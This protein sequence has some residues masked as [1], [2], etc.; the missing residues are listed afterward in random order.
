MLLA[1][2]PDSALAK[3]SPS[4]EHE[5]EVDYSFE[6][7]CDREQLLRV[8]YDFSHL[9]E[10]MTDVDKLEI[11]QKTPLSYNVTYN[12]KYLFYKSRLIF[13]KTLREKDDMVDFVLLSHWDNVS[14]LPKLV[15]VR[16]YWKVEEG[17]SSGRLKVRYYQRSVFD[18]DIGFF[19]RSVLKRRSHIEIVLKPRQ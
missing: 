15:D 18:D 9:V 14:F 5:Y 8:L 11:S 12:Y 4:K 7:D 3:D 17:D 2:S 6:T 19:Y 1:L 16:G 13:R 10:F